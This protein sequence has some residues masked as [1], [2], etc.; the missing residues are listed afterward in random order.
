MVVRILT[1]TNNLTTTMNDWSE[2]NWQEDYLDTKAR[3]SS[4]D[5]NLL[6]NGAKTWIQS[7]YIGL[8]K[9]RWMKMRGIASGDVD[10]VP[11]DGTTY[12]SSFL[13]FTSRADQY[14][15]E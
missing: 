5:R 1:V 2:E 8:L 4:Y 3:V 13:E 15:K 11:N 10:N 14:I 7:V 12:Q 9:R 6:E